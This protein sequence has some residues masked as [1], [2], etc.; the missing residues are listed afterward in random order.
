MQTVRRP[1]AN[2]GILSATNSVFVA[3]KFM[4][5]F[6]SVQPGGGDH[7]VVSGIEE[8][9]SSSDVRR[10]DSNGMWKKGYR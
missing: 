9:R 7:S 5:L 1:G 6:V 8:D 3:D 10:H 2:V 4:F